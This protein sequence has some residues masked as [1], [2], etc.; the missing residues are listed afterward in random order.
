MAWDL[1]TWREAHRP[2]R[3]TAG[4]VT[5]TARHVSAPQCRAYEER[6]ADAKGNHRH[7]L[8]AIRWMLRRAFPWRF[9]YLIRGDPVR[10]IMGLEPPAQNAALSDFF[11]CLRGVEPPP[12]PM[13]QRMNGTPSRVS[14]LTR[15]L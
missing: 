3:F 7:T 4:G 2:W 5:W 12:P 6:L 9:S 13:S 11:A 14:T 10:V 15:S 1:N 8:A